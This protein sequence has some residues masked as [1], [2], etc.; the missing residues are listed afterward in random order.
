[1]D[2]QVISKQCVSSGLPFQPPAGVCRI[3]MPLPHYPNVTYLRRQ[4]WH[5]TPSCNHCGN[6][7]AGQ[8]HAVYLALTQ[9][10]AELGA[11]DIQLG[12]RTLHFWAEKKSKGSRQRWSREMNFTAWSPTAPHLD[13]QTEELPIWVD[14]RGARRS[15]ANFSPL[16]SPALRLLDLSL[17]TSYDFS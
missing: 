1:M 8:T 12:T 9:A 2:R 10:E 16:V 7:S 5:R 13:S 3:S 15:P 17:G 4:V 11:G 14:F 6:F